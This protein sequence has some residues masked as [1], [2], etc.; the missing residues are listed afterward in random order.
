MV[1]AT[2]EETLSFQNTIDQIVRTKK[3]SFIDAIVDYSNQKNIEIE[4]IIPLINK[5]L[6]TKIS[7]DAKKLNLLKD[8]PSIKK[9]RKR[10]A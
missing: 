7:V 6:K 3:I 8:K 10:K 5:Q 1:K 9:K 2:K 4:S